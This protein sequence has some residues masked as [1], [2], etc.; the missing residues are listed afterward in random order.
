V[1]GVS[2]SARQHAFRSAL[3]FAGLAVIIAR[4][5][6]GRLG[7]FDQAV[8][9]MVQNRRRPRAVTA[10]R[11]VSACAEPGFVVFPVIGASAAAGRRAGWRHACLP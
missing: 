2:G 10:A 3:A 1:A 9:G 5:G 4:A 6:E 8:T 7:R 11:A